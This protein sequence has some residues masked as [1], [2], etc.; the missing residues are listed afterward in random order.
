MTLCV[1]HLHCRAFNLTVTRRLWLLVTRVIVS[2]EALDVSQSIDADL[3][4][5]L[6]AVASA[7]GRATLNP[8]QP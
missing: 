5:P 4:V 1:R 6:I 7:I 2:S 8:A 3:I